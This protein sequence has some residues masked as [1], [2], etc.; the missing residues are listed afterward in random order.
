MT[1]KTGN[2]AEL[3]NAA[4]RLLT[5]KGYT[6]RDISSGSGVPKLSRLE[7]ECGRE[8]LTC[9]VKASAT[10][11][12]RISF[13]RNPDGTYKVLS[14]SD[15]VVYVRNVED[16]ATKV[17]IAMFDATTVKQAFEDNFNALQGVGN[18]HLPMWLSPELETGK[19]FIGSGF[20]D[21]ALWTEIRPLADQIGASATSKQPTASSTP[22]ASKDETAMGIMD[23]IKTRL[24]DH[25]GVRPDQLE[26]DIRVKL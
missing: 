26:I 9:A 3:R 8:K 20:Q 15:R 11:H 16:D 17:L 13:T 25:M 1:K 4:I 10:R 2:D 14:D 23:R 6:V 12:G 24:A 18:E 22:A 19:R 5:E 7:I 21:K